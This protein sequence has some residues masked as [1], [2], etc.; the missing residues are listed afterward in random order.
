MLRHFQMNDFG[1]HYIES[2][3]VTGFFIEQAVLSCISNHGLGLSKVLRKPSAAVV[4]LGDCLPYNLGSKLILY[5]PLSFYLR[6]ICGIILQLERPVNPT[7]D[8]K[9]VV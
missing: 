9:S 1:D 4:F 3:S 5:C 6:G 8:R 7:K 2:P